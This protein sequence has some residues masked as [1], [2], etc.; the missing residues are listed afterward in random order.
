MHR[1]CHFLRIRAAR[2]GKDQASKKARFYA[3]S[4]GMITIVTP[5]GEYV[6]LENNPRGQYLWVENFTGMLITE[7]IADTLVEQYSWA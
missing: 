1:F 4:Q 3:R 2:S 6:F 5:D 7:A